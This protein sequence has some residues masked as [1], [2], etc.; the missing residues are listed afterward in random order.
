MMQE[1]PVLDKEEEDYEDEYS[2]RDPF[3]YLA[4]VSP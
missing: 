3:G 4:E 2:H 1:K